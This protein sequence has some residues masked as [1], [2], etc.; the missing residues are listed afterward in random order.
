M[1][2]VCK[3]VNSIIK[4]WQEAFGDSKEEI[5]YFIN[6]AKHAKCLAYYVDNTVVSML[7]L[8]DCEIVGSKAEYLYAVC[9]LKE[10]QRS[11]Y[12]SKLLDYCKEHYEMLCLIPAN[13][14]LIKFYKDR[15]FTNSADISDIEFDET[16]EICEYLLE[17]FKLT[18]PKALCYIKEKY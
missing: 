4:L 16:D 14:S 12:S 15:E 8:V 9:T 11:G 1:I 17:G 7:F 18:D 10:H 13:D 2:K 3:D 5:L 6:D